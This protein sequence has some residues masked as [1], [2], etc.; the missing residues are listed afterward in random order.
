[1]LSQFVW[2]KLPVKIRYQLA[3]DLKL[4]RTMPTHVIHNVVA[5]DG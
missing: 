5:S 3:Q 1:M 4:M 2:L